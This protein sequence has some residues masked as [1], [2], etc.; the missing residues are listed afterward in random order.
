MLI[1]QVA[2]E[3]LSMDFANKAFIHKDLSS[4]LNQLWDILNELYSNNPG[5]VVECIYFILSAPSQVYSSM[6]PELH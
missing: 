4:K 6:Q 3:F 2:N 5:S 1:D